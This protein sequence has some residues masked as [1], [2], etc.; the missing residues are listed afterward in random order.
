MPDNVVEMEALPVPRVLR[1]GDVDCEEEAETRGL[2]EEEDEIDGDLDEITLLDLVGVTVEDTDFFVVAD[3]MTETDIFPLAV[4]DT[5]GPLSLYTVPVEQ[6]EG[7]FERVSDDDVDGEL[8]TVLVPSVVWVV[9]AE[10][11]AAV[12]V[13]D[14]ET[15][16]ETEGV[17]ESEL[18]ADGVFEPVEDKDEVAE[19]RTDTDS[20]TDTLALFVTLTDAVSDGV[21][22]ALRVTLFTEFVEFDETELLLDVEIVALGDLLAVI[23]RVAV[24]LVDGLRDVTDVTDELLL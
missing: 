9:E 10:Y 3:L 1:D 15:D 13:V 17:C 5:D 22:L 12:F 23:V 7:V 16:D 11:G 8:V 18:E 19:V 24:A 2:E 14:T 6:G 20:V 21:E 4:D